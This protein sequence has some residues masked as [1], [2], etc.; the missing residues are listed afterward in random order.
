MDTQNEIAKFAYELYV[1]SGCKEGRDLDNWL[2]AER[3][4]AA[5]ENV[6]VESKYESEGD[7]ILAEKENN[8][9]EHPVVL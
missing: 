3:I 1:D 9:E 4:L 8:F 5:K 7:I 2:E 6:E